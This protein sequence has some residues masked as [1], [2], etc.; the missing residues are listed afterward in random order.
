MAIRVML[1][2]APEVIFLRA[3]KVPVG[4]WRQR[5][6]DGEIKNAGLVDYGKH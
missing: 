4:H 5:L 6:V 2:W 3:E 1:D